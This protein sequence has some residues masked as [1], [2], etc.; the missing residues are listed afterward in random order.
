MCRSSKKFLIKIITIES[1]VLIRTTLSL[2][3]M[4]KF[5]VIKNC[6]DCLISYEIMP[7]VIFLTQEMKEDILEQVNNRIGKMMVEIQKEIVV[8]P[9]INKQ[10]SEALNQSCEKR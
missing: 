9:E 10:M 2:D 7:R 1:H 5:E 6:L 8:N 3:R 4:R